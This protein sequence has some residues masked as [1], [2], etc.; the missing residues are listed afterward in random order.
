MERHLAQ[1]A[2]TGV[3][4]ALVGFGS[5]FAVVLAGLSAVGATST[6]AASGLMALC[7][8]QALAMLYLSW[9]HRIP[10]TIAW[11]TPGAALLAT[12]GYVDGGWPAAVGAF[13]VTGTLIMAIG[14]IAPLARLVAAIPAAL[15]QAMLA[16]ILLPLCLAPFLALGDSP[17]LMGCLIVTWVLLERFARR[18][19][20]PATFALAL[21]AMVVIAGGVDL[22]PVTFALTA[23]T[24]TWQAVIGLAVPL[25][26]VTMAS[27]NV[28]GV[29]V[30]S[31]HGYTVPW[32]SAM[33]AT[34]LGTL[35]GAPAG[36]HAINLAAITAALPASEQAHPDPR[37]RWVA[38]V[39]AG[40]AYL[41]L[42]TS[43][44]TL[45][46]LI[47]AGP[48]GLIG[49]VAGLALL[50]TLANAVAGAMAATEDRI[51]AAL[52]LLI[53]ASGIAIVGIGSAFWA[54]LVGLTVRWLWRTGG[55]A[56]TR[57]RRGIGP[58]QEK[59]PPRG[60]AGGGA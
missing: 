29:A 30:L 60:G 57:P 36:G 4:T 27:Q 22:V 44:G 34:G 31:A 15:A 52:T 40:V 55:E 50:G 20:T 18:W 17:W 28:P 56:A 26:I 37:R 46:A 10:L 21:G 35:I 32:R 1:A 2:A 24:L 48:D 53:A 7:V 23:P 6:E 16:G 13:L 3:V 8:T 39:F 59:A 42:A 38:T 19:A 54:L 51:P 49:A 14:V 12:Q 58:T 47:D 25:T 5:S 45:T 33:L 43:V 41:V 9:R 11:S